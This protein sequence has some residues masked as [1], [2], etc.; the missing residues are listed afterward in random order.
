MAS[1]YLLLVLPALVLA[2]IDVQLSGEFNDDSH[3][4]LKVYYSGSQAGVITDAERTTF[5][6][7]DA[8]LKDS[9]GAYF[10]RRPDDAY[11]RSPTP[12]GDL[13][14]TFGWDQVLSTLVPKNGKI[15]GITSQPMIITKQLFEN[16]SSKPATFDVGISQSVQNTVKSSWSQ[17]G[18][19][20]V[21]QEINY[22]FDIEF[23][24]GGGKTAFSYTSTWGRNTE[25]SESVTIGSQSGMK[26]LLQPGQAVVAQLQATKGTIRMEV[27]YEA[28]LSGASAVN[29]D[30]GYRGHHF[31]S[32]D[33]RA[34]MASVGLPN[35]KVSKE[36]IEIDFYSQS[37][38]VV[39]D[40]STNI[41]LME[42]GF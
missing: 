5:G 1:L 37:R 8:I 30:D 14:S 13:Y 38:V 28:S 4:N 7:S 26:I 19:L 9:I 17:G 27:E 15:L 20:N 40:K 34:I 32:L 18:S 42:I 12:W 25:K 23:I 21:A 39:N 24:K 36:V 3:N 2:R 6:L 35:Q 10:G 11:L 29:Y 31:W 33:I 16:N 22:G 41:K